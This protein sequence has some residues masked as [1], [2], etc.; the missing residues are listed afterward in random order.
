L[1]TANNKAARKSIVQTVSHTARN[2]TV[3]SRLKTLSKK[4]FALAKVGSSEAKGVAS[5]YMS[6]LD[7]AVKKSIIHCKAAN[8][9]KF[10]I[11]GNF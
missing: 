9:K 11:K 8:R 5:E 1:Q 4:V 7:K 3:R 6:E 10:F 2:R